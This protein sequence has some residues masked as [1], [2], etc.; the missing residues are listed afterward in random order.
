M[1][2]NEDKARLTYNNKLTTHVKH[3]EKCVH[4]ICRGRSKGLQKTF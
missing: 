1:R 3:T 2:I 4:F